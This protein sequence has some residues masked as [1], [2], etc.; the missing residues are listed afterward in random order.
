[1]SSVEHKVAMHRLARER[2]RQGKSVWEL[3]VRGVR[4]VLESFYDDFITTR[5]AVVRA[6]EMSSWYQ[7]TNREEHRQL[8]D[9]LDELR[10]VGSP[11]IDWDDDYDEVEHFNACMNAIYDLA[12]YHRVWID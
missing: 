9:I 11:D 2:H 12:D 1:M 8:E 4:S 7:D 6:F 5:D 10:D 3:T